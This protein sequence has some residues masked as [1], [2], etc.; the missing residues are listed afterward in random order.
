MSTA[1][2][3]NQKRYGL[4]W[5]HELGHEGNLLQSQDCF[6][7]KDVKVGV[8]DNGIYLSH[9]GLLGLDPQNGFTIPRGSRPVTQSEENLD[10]EADDR[11]HGTHVAGIIAAGGTGELF[12]VCPNA[13]IIDYPAINRGKDQ[14]EMLEKFESSLRHAID[15]GVNVINMSIAIPFSWYSE[16]LKNLIIEAYN[17]GIVICVASGNDGVE[18]GSSLCGC[19]S[20]VGIVLNV[21]NY[22]LTVGSVEGV[23]HNASEIY[24]HEPNQFRIMNVSNSELLA[25]SYFTNYGYIS[26]VENGISGPGEY[27][28][29][30]YPNNEYTMMAGTSMASPFIA[31]FAAMII[32]FLKKKNITYT[33][34]DIFNIMKASTLPVLRTAIVDGS[35]MPIEGMDLLAI[36]DMKSYS[37]QFYTDDFRETDIYIKSWNKFNG[38]GVPNFKLLSRIL[39]A[40]AFFGPGTLYTHVLTDTENPLA[41]QVLPENK[42]T[43]LKLSAA[44]GWPDVG[45]PAFQNPT[46]D[47][48][49]TAVI[50]S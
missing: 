42:N 37:N 11:Q 15:S 24:Y 36:N 48:Q 32:G 26:F 38:F 18:T 46:T 35:F 4:Q 1:Y 17:S 41:S 21:K 12:G 6:T 47:S 3:Y 39:M 9:V 50:N 49:Y 31:G 30:L 7:G 45:P 23:W 16:T 10:W 5:I 40:Y 19:L 14:D 28:I 22:L 29:S 2:T 43:V 8:V 25:K 20:S 44:P 13:Q 33:A 34:K 27:V